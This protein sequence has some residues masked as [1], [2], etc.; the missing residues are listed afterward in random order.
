MSLIEEAAKTGFLFGAN[1]FRLWDWVNGKF[2]RLISKKQIYTPASLK[3]TWSEIIASKVKHGDYIHFSGKSNNYWYLTDWVPKSPG[4]IWKN[5]NLFKFTPEEIKRSL[6]Y[7]G[8]IGKP[9]LIDLYFNEHAHWEN[10]Y[11]CPSTINI[12][13]WEQGFIHRTGIYRSKLN[14]INEDR[15]AILSAVTNNEYFIDLA[16]PILVSRQVYEKFI[17]TRVNG[18]SVEFDGIV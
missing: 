7:E 2:D 17:N 15:Y 8:I 5:Y 3:E 12:S 11:F 9:E 6:N 1:H 10:R 13:L 16:F 18:N 4:A 14:Y